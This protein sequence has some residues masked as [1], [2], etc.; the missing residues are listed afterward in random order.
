LLE[1]A[2]AYE[3]GAAIDMCMVR[4]DQLV[5]EVTEGAFIDPT[6]IA[7][8][9]LAD[10]HELGVRIAVDDFGTGYSSLAYLQRLP[11]EEL[12][13]DRSFVDGIDR[14]RHEGAA[15]LA[16]VRMCDSMGLRCVAEGV[17]RESQI[18]PL[19]DAGCELAQGFLFGR[20]MSIAEALDLLRA[21]PPVPRRGGVRS[22]D[23]RVA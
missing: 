8:Q 1:P 14:G 3:V 2:F 21:R 11:V 23:L 15:A 19:L 4:G 10:L 6:S 22:P 5:L 18:V 9:Q 12:K 13:I 20:P 7:S 16:I 17:E